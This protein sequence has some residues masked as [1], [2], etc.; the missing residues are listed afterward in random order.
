MCIGATP[1]QEGF[2]DCKSNGNIGCKLG[3]LIP[4]HKSHKLYMDNLFSGVPLYLEFLHRGIFC[5]G[6]VRLNRLPRIK[7]CMIT[8]SDLK[9]KG[10]SSFTEYEGTVKDKEGKDGK[11][12]ESVGS[13]RVVRWNDNNICTLMSSM[14]SGHPITQ[15]RRWDKFE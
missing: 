12:K 6:T 15:V 11:I 4:V 3:S 8:D 14:G 13:V 1:K 5:M 9:A 10:R 2:A 7:T